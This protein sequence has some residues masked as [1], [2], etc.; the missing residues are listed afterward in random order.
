MPTIN[1]RVSERLYDEIKERADHWQLDMSRYLRLCIWLVS[2]IEERDSDI[3][4]SDLREAV[5]L[6]GGSIE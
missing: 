4:R 2:L 1:V 6:I 3:D 5:R